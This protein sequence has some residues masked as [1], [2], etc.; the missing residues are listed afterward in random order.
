MLRFVWGFTLFVFGISLVFWG[1]GYR[2]NVS[3]SFPKG[4]WRISH[5]HC[6][7]D[8][9][10]LKDEMVLFRPPSTPI[11]LEARRRGYIGFGF[12]RGFMQPLLKKV[13]GVSGDVVLVTS[14]GVSVNGRLL[15]NSAPFAYDQLGREMSISEGRVLDNGELWVM[16]DYSAHSFDSRYFGVINFD[17][18][19]FPIP[20]VEKVFMEN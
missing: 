6:D 11:F 1:L 17:S 15:E 10:L 12:G 18:I 3:D 19:P 2:V 20:I 8:L 14:F 16:S 9:A 13:V 4:I 7:L 5:Y